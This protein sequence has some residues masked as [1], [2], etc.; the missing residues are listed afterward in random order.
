MESVYMF[1]RPRLVRSVGC[2]LLNWRAV[3][4]FAVRVDLPVLL[5]VSPLFTTFYNRL[6]RL[7][8]LARGD[9]Y[10]FDGRQHG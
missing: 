2:K 4:E 9:R 5:L 7:D 3:A 8:T 10:S 6:L 1:G